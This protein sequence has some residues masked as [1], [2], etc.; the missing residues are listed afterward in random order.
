MGAVTA[1]KVYIK[2]LKV[3]NWDINIVREW[4]FDVTFKTAVYSKHV[5]AVQ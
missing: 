4:Y 1:L 3:S 2:R 5:F